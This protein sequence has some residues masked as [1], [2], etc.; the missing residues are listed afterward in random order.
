[1]RRLFILV[2]LRLVTPAVTDFQVSSTPFVM[3]FWNH[4]GCQ[5]VPSHNATVGQRIFSKREIFGISNEPELCYSYSGGPGD[6]G[7]I[8]WACSGDGA[9]VTQTLYSSEDCSGKELTEAHGQHG[10]QLGGAPKGAGSDGR[11]SK[12]APFP[13]RRH[14]ASEW[15]AV[16][17]TAGKCLSLGGPMGYSIGVNRSV[18]ESER[19]Y[20][21]QTSSTMEAEIVNLVSENEANE[22]RL[23]RGTE[24]LVQS[25]ARNEHEREVFFIAGSSVGFLVGALTVTGL[26]KLRERNGKWLRPPDAGARELSCSMLTTGSGDTDEGSFAE[27]RGPADEEPTR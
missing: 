17:L 8:K 23:R 14:W 22:K 21:T 18:P 16:A 12:K 24:R 1:M 7:S 20:C 26:Y 10:S 9:G 2:F 4:A 3:K 25:A 11:P 27:L 13:F 6:P 19:P 5:G 15:L